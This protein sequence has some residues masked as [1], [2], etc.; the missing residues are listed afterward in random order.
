MSDDAVDVADADRGLG[1]SPLSDGY[2]LR[3]TTPSVEAFRRLRREAGMT[4][5]SRGAVERGLPNTTFGV[6]VVETASGSTVGMARLV[7][8]GG[9]VFHLSDTAVAPPHQGRGIG[10]AM[11]GALVAWLRA[12]APDGAYVNRF[13]DVDGFYERWGFERTAPASKAMGIRTE[14]L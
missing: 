7:G 6:H 11:V 5:R 13:A 1:E 8:D 4:D 9:S 10:T 3:E 2:E 14:E 12:N